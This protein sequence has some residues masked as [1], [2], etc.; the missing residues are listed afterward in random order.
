[1]N[2]Q[3]R[4]RKLREKSGYTLAEA[5]VAILL[6]SLLS[7]SIATGV[8]FGVKQYSYAVS[9]SEAR[10]LCS[11][12]E[13]IVRDELRNAS[14]ISIGSADAAGLASVTGYGISRNFTPS[15][16]TSLSSFIATEA[17]NGFGYLAV[18]TNAKDPSSG[19]EKTETL[20]LLSKAAYSHKAQKLTA[21]VDVKYHQDKGY[22][23]VQLW[24]KAPDSGTVD[25]TFDVFPLNQLI[26]T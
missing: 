3:G 19:E 17:S 26:I 6:I 22:F 4:R 18:K 11:T 21:K 10:V 7:M 20:L 13:N 9:R 8:A 14:T 2:K 1:M 23:Q 5:L 25:T 15:G 24:V 16:A 12:L